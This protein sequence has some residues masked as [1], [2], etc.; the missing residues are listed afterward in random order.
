M[1]LTPSFGLPYPDGDDTADTPRDIQALAEATA[2]ELGVTQSRAVNAGSGLTGGGTIAADRT[3]NVGQGTGIN[4]QADSVNVD[5]VWSDARYINT[6]GDTMTAP[7]TLVPA[8]PTLTGHAA[9]KG[10][11]DSRIWTGTQAAY[12]AIA[13]KDPTVLYVII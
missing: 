12:D 13:T 6:D 3:V 8:A 1:P 2:R 11:V 10:Y 5:T 9:H 7:L 4:V